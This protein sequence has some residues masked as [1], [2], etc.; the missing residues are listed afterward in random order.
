MNIIDKVIKKTYRGIDNFDMIQKGDHVMIAVSWGKDSLAMLEIM[1]HLKKYSDLNFS[2]TAVYI[3]PEIPWIKVLSTKI[4][5]VFKS[6]WI[7]YIIKKMNIPEKSKLREGIE[8]AKTCQWCAYSRRIALFKIAEEIKADKIIY[9]HHMDDMIHTL[10]Q[11]IYI[12]S[13][14]KIMLPVNKMRKWDFWIIRPFVYIREEEIKLFCKR[15]EIK[16]LKASC[17]L[18]DITNRKLMKR[19]V[20]D[21]EK[22]LPNFAEKALF[23]YIERF[24]DEI[25]FVK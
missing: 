9:G 13:H 15:K 22:K 4:E 21:I 1:T 17:P 20:D 6:Y 2:I 5:K 12:G 3:I 14:L 16:P 23:S 18:N 25:N 24:P 7:N 10:F 8:E 11:N 19:V